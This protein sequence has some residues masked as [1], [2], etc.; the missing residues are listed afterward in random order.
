MTSFYQPTHRI[1]K[2]A[3]IVLEYGLDFTWRKI[4]WMRNRS[5]KSKTRNTRNKGK[6]DLG[7][8]LIFMFCV[9]VATCFAAK[10]ILTRNLERLF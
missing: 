8:T 2:M 7:K 6:H 9:I 5:I 1:T 4:D 10:K 3:S